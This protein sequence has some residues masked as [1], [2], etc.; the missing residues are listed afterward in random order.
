MAKLNKKAKKAAAKAPGPTGRRGGGTGRASGSCGE[1]QLH[2]Q[3]VRE[4]VDLMVANDL[5]TLEISD[6]RLSVSLGRVAP[7]EAAAPPPVLARQALPEAPEPAEPAAAD[8]V[9]IRSPMVGTF[10]TSPSPEIDAYVEV[11]TPVTMDTPVCIIEAMKVMNEIKA[12]CTGTIAEIGVE[13]G[14]PVEYGQILFRVK[15]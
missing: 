10:Y 12:E 2:V 1:D 14:Q 7:A 9:A 8:L 3:Q 11:G 15:P 4:L 6:G 13:N 5:T